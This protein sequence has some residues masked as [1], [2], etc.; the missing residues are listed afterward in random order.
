MPELCITVASL[1]VAL[2]LVQSYLR[3]KEPAP[4]RPLR[5]AHNGSANDYV[6]YAGVVALVAALH[7]A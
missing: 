1:V 2:F 3:H 4:V 6:A 7:W 5:A